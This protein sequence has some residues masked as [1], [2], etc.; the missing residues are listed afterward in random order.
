MVE[1]LLI[2]AH[3]RFSALNP[4]HLGRVKRLGELYAQPNDAQAN[5]PS[6]HLK[7][8][9]TQLTQAS[10]LP[11]FRSSICWVSSSELALRLLEYLAMRYPD[12][13]RVLVHTFHVKSYLTVPLPTIAQMIAKSLLDIFSCH[14]GACASPLTSSSASST[15]SLSMASNTSLLS[16]S[17]TSLLSVGANS[18]NAP[19]T[20]H[21]SASGAQHTLLGTTAPRDSISMLHSLPNTLVMPA[22]LP[23]DKGSTA[24]HPFDQA[25]L[26]EISLLLFDGPKCFEEI[27]SWAM[28]IF[29]FLIFDKPHLS[30][31]KFSSIVQKVQHRLKKILSKTHKMTDF[32]AYAN[33][34]VKPT[35]S[36]KSPSA[37]NAAHTNATDSSSEDSNSSAQNSNSP[38]SGSLAEKQN[39]ISRIVIAPHDE[40]AC[41]AIVSLTIIL[42]GEERVI[43]SASPSII[44]QER[45]NTPSISL[46]SSSESTGAPPISENHVSGRKSTDSSPSRRSLSRKQTE[47]PKKRKT[48][49]QSSPGMVEM[50]GWAFLKQHLPVLLNALLSASKYENTSFLV[51]H[52]VDSRLFVNSMLKLIWKYTQKANGGSV[53]FDAAVRAQNRS[54]GALSVTSTP[55]KAPYANF[56]EYLRLNNSTAARYALELILKGCALGSNHRSS[57]ISFVTT[58]PTSQLATTEETPT[59]NA[60]TAITTNLTSSSSINKSLLFSKLIACDLVSAA[61]VHLTPITKPVIPLALLLQQQ[62]VSRIEEMANFHLD[63]KKSDH[64][65]FFNSF[66]ISC[67]GETAKPLTGAISKQWLLLGFESEDPT[68][69][70]KSR[71]PIHCL[72]WMSENGPDRLDLLLT[73]R[74]LRRPGDYSFACVVVEL[75]ELMPRLVKDVIDAQ[76]E[77]ISH[78]L[79]VLFTS[80][81]FFEQLVE[82]CVY[83]FDTI[84]RAQKFMSHKDNVIACVAHIRLHLFAALQ[85][86]PTFERVIL[87]LKASLVMFD[88]SIPIDAPYASHANLSSS[89]SLPSHTRPP[90]HSSPF[91]QSIEEAYDAY[92]S[93]RQEKIAK[94]EVERKRAP[95]RASTKSGNPRRRS[96]KSTNA[97]TV[98]STGALAVGAQLSADRNSST[99]PEPSSKPRDRSASRKHRKQMTSTGIVGNSSGNSASTPNMQ[100]YSASVSELPVL[101]PPFDTAPS[102]STTS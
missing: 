17:N 84:W 90:C 100:L 31:S 27:F 3:R 62:I 101:D 56:I 22:C 99:S 71:L 8:A 45:S 65:K 10:E 94:L 83:I 89:S 40:E 70:L 69:L 28:Y 49:G 51:P 39:L 6:P 59:A 86:E 81:Y 35:F 96:L 18:L 55:Q 16:N 38:Y 60:S 15:S 46:S 23:H 7:L 42:E 44:G 54:H 41:D 102:A 14:P 37:N 82:E 19:S 75:S 32:Q 25:K 29:Y 87:S 85:C 30:M 61:S 74:L 57:S 78:L 43:R 64:L 5:A 53:D 63:A 72:T 36:L 79:P 11:I 2:F 66:W 67:L 47:S 92:N 4:A 20:N 24:V 13:F 48:S 97:S 88:A 52:I 21:S 80:A 73:E 58:T 33:K 34:V 95:K 98:S 26:P 76:S 68:T 93:D 12:L 50:R 9:T 91:I 77:A 1:S